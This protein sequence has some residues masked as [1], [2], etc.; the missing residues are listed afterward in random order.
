MATTPSRRRRRKRY[1]IPLAL[2]LLLVVLAIV[3]YWRGTAGETVERNPRSS[4]DGS[5]TQLIT[6]DGQTFIRCAVVVDAPPQSVWQVVTDYVSQQDYLPYLSQ[7]ATKR[8]EDGKVEITGI[9]HSRIWGDW[10]F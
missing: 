9:A 5:V 8:R 7:I 3:V 4:A 6:R 10:P 2:L 1:V